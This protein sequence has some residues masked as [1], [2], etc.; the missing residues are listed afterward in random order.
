MKNTR[1]CIHRH[2]KEAFRGA[3]QRLLCLTAGATLLLS[4]GCA[5]EKTPEPTAPLLEEHEAAQTSAPASGGVL[6]V[7]IPSN[8][9]SFDPLTAY[10]KELQNLLSLVY[11]PLLTYDSTN[12]LTA[13]LAETWSTPDEGVTWEINLRRDVRWHG[14]QDTMTAKDV[15]F[16]YNLLKSK[17]YAHSPY[18][19]LVERIASMEA[20]DEYKLVVA[21]KEPGMQVLHSL[22]FPV[23]SKLHYQD[24]LGTGPYSLAY[25]NPSVGAELTANENWWKR[26]PYISRV[27]AQCLQEESGALPLLQIQ[28]V[29]FVTTS[30]LTANTYR[31]EGVNSLVELY[32]QHSEMLLLNQNSWRLQ[33][34]NVRKAIAYALDRREII[35]KVYYNHAFACDVPVPPDSWLY[36]SASKRY[37]VDL[38]KAKELLEQAGWKDYDGD[39]I[40]DK[41]EEGGIARLRLTLVVNDTPDNLTRQDAAKLIA[42]QLARVGIEVQISA[43]KWTETENAY[44][45]AL[46]AG[47]F[48]LAL[49]GVNLGRN[50]DLTELLKTGGGRNYGRY[51]STQMDG[52][53]KQAAAAP[54][55]KELKE[56]MTSIQSLFVEELPFIH[57]YFRTYSVVYSAK[58]SIT[59]DLR[60]TEPFR[61]IEKWFFTPEGIALYSDMTLASAGAPPKL[62][63]LASG[64]APE[65]EDP[66][67]R[68]PGG[69]GE[70]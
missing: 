37:D 28:E 16:T 36:D 69:E 45:T 21:G 13:A 57:L 9:S 46:E 65:E 4:A 59:Q 34:K 30:S 14:R 58:L 56:V 53:L 20:V 63:Q 31:E 10:S 11:E 64:E 8:V 38:D 17:A 41:R 51:S 33:D 43:L 29:N 42:E 27:V 61:S 67:G 70:R 5:A 6:A 35:S 62:E 32:T 18:Y 39:G 68:E 26:T 50:G 12:R 1:T 25:A 19:E 24:N 44:Q 3:F 66:D 54:S 15:L 49:M 22:V 2:F 60:D 47:G 7:N 40:R 55:E 23:V 52:L 48:D